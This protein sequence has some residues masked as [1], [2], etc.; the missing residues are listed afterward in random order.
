MPLTF[1]EQANITDYL[2]GINDI[3]RPKTVDMKNIKPGKLNSAVTM[4]CRMILMRKGTIP[5]IPDLGVDITGRYRFAFEEELIDLENDIQN[6]INTYLPEFTP[7][8]VRCELVLDNEKHKVI[9]HL[10]INEIEY[11]IAYLVDDNTLEGLQTR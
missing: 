11:L 3:N 8:T 7:V 1:D 10:I 6:Q 5:D 4:I 2:I 9:I